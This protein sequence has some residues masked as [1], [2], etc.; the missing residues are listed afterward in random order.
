MTL[1]TER[2][3]FEYLSGNKVNYL[4]FPSYECVSAV[5]VIESSVKSV[6]EVSAVKL[7]CGKN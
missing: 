2:N 7:A 1:L 6:F 3:F 4:Q 5:P